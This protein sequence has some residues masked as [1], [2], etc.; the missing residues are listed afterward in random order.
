M[1][2]DLQIDEL[3]S[4]GQLGGPQHDQILRGVLEQTATPHRW[5]RRMPAGRLF[6]LGFVLAAALGGWLILRR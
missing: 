5:W 4:R 1:R 2:D 6:V 3:L